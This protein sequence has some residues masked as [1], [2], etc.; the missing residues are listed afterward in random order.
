MSVNHLAIDPP[1]KVVSD[2]RLWQFRL[3]ETQPCDPDKPREIEKRLFT[4]RDAV[5]PGE[6]WYDSTPDAINGGKLPPP[7]KQETEADAAARF[8]QLSVAE[9]VALL[10]AQAAAVR[11]EAEKPQEDEAAKGEGEPA[12]GEP[13][14]R[15]RKPKA[16]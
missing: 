15:K 8:D 6:G 1:A 11:G 5:P 9:Q 2:R 12:G 3:A 14:E 16:A 7:S 13:R 4:S 10:E